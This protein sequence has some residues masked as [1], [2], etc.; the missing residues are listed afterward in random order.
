MQTTLNFVRKLDLFAVRVQLSYKGQRFFGTAF[1]GCISLLLVLSFLSVVAFELNRSLMTPVLSSS[2][3]FNYKALDE[4][5]LVP[6]KSSTVAVQITNAG[7]AQED[8]SKQVRVYF[9]ENGLGISAVYCKDF[10]AE[11]IKAEEEA[12]EDGFFT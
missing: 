10:Y 12:G 9:S 8:I 3:D 5:F 1:G 4:Q 7:A 2:I 11:E 6:T